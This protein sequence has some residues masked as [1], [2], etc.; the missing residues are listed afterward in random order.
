MKKKKKKLE[1]ARFDKFIMEGTEAA[2][3]LAKAG[4][5]VDGGAMDT[6]NAAT[7]RQQRIQVYAGLQDTA[8]L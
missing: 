8:N 1:I 5:D 6:L 2:D 7:V 4:T 3:Q